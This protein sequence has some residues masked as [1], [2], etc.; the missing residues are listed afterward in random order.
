MRKLDWYILRKFLG[1]FVLTMVLI[2][3]IA[4]VFDISEKLDDF[5]NGAELHEI[6][7]DYYVNFVAFYGNLFSALILFISTIWFTSRITANSEIVAILTSG[8]SF[9]RLLRPYW[10]GA[11]IICLISLALNHLVVPQTNIKR[12]AFEEKYVTGVNRPINQ[13][14]HRQVL[15]GHYVY[16][17]TFS[18]TRHSGYQFTYE[19][20]EDHKLA[21]KL[22]ADFVR[23]DTAIGKWRLDNY[24]LR[25]VDSL[26]QEH[27]LSGRRLDTAL[28]FTSEQIA[29]KLNSIA[30]MNS[31]E[32][33]KFIAQE[34]I[35]GNENI[36]SYQMEMQR[37]SSY[38]LSAYVFVLLAVALASQKRRGG[39]GINIAIGLV[40]SAI[41]IFT[42]QI[43]QTFATTGILS[44]DGWLGK[45]LLWITIQPAEFAIW[46]PNILFAGVAIW[47]YIVAP[48]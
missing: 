41:Y 30:T 24:N 45:T 47:R 16:F 10:I 23:L 37:R 7:F 18:G 36:A 25:T 21:S 35:T 40:L 4:I 28:S 43:S 15:P 19:V 9:R 42:M 11:T 20:F 46:I 39:L 48:K 38:P 22:S 3:S 44:T 5:Q 14:V 2:L 33:S 32:L 34:E 29:P 31:R 6:I 13:K 8:T 1:S 27:I 26:G 12:I 17:E